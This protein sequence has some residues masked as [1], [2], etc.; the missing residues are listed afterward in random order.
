[1]MIDEQFSFYNIHGGLMSGNGD[2]TIAEIAWKDDGF[3]FL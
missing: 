3:G 1:M 2:F